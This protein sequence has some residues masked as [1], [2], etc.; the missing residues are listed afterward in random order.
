[1]VHANQSW[2]AVEGFPLQDAERSPERPVLIDLRPH[3]HIVCPVEVCCINP[4]AERCMG[5][6]N[7]MGKHPG[8]MLLRTIGLI[9]PYRPFIFCELLHCGMT[10]ILNSF[11]DLNTQNMRNYLY[12]H[13]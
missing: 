3:I 8:K 7:H 12:R 5:I 11:Q 6:V 9:S 2:L 1:M 13:V 4:S 10:V